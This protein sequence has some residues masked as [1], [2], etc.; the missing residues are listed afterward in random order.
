MSIMY[1]SRS[2]ILPSVDIN[3][4][5]GFHFLF[6]FNLSSISLCFSVSSFFF[7]GSLL[8]FFFEET[9]ALVA[10]VVAGG[11]EDE[12][13]E[14]DEE[15]KNQLNTVDIVEDEVDEATCPSPSSSTIH[16][17]MD[18]TF[19]FPGAGKEL[20]PSLSL[21]LA[22]PAGPVASPLPTLA[23]LLTQSGTRAPHTS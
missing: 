20:G 17:D 21:L 1:T 14:E 6:F 18:G 19:T 16:A 11:A 4:Q 5:Q 3:K 13:E 9:E 10:D 7:F 2:L 8:A 15:P 23:A 12:E 22:R